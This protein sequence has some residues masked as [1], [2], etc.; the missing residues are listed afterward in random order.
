MLPPAT[1]GVDNMKYTDKDRYI[2]QQ[3]EQDETMMVLIYAQWCVNNGIDAIALY[4]QAYPEQP[5]NNLLLDAIKQTI[6][7]E[8]SE[9]ISKDIV[10]QVLQLYGN[11]DLAFEIQAIKISPTD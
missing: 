7:K 11:D 8:E 10:L 2:I 1:K 5:K 6:P 4:E 3:Y 9:Y